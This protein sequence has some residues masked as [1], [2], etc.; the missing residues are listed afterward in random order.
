M[1]L[2][3]VLLIAAFVGLL[4][5]AFRNRARVGLRAGTRIAVIALTALAVASILQPNIT[6]AMA[7]FVGVTRGTDLVFY[8]VSVAFVINCIS[9]YFRFREQDRRMVEIVR[10]SAIR[11][12][13]LSQ[14]IPGSVNDL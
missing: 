9:T 13:I 6:Q 1:T 12:A 4:V 14:G 11:D 10:A 7:D 2:I 8:G 3:K 5:W